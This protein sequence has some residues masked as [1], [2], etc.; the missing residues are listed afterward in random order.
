LHDQYLQQRLLADV[1]GL[2]DHILAFVKWCPSTKSM[3]RFVK[4]KS[5][6]RTLLFASS[7]KTTTDSKET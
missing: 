7:Y 1:V 4:K 2:G 5:M 3:Q 6:Q